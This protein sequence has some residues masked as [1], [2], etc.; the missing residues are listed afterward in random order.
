LLFSVGFHWLSPLFRSIASRYTSSSISTEC[1]QCIFPLPAA[2]HGK[3]SNGTWTIF[4]IRMPSQR[5][6]VQSWGCLLL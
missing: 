4:E 6:I 1:P 3:P 5:T 2:K